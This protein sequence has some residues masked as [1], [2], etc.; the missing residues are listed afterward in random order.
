MWMSDLELEAIKLKKLRELQRRIIN[1]KTQQIKEE[2]PLKIVEG[3]LV[4]RGREVLEAAYSQFPDAA[5]MV[6]EYL[7]KLVKE[8]KLRG[9]LTGEELYSIFKSLGLHV[10]LET[11][12]VFK[13][14]GKVKSLIEKLKED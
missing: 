12:I 4:G 2:D 5:K 9:T 3:I 6:V 11:R 14:H 13:E 1:H 8:G 7:A 10:K